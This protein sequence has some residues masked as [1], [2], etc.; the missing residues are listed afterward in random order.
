MSHVPCTL[1]L[2][3]CILIY[4]T[5]HIIVLSTKPNVDNHA[6][7]IW[8]R[9]MGVATIANKNTPFMTFVR[10]CHSFLSILKPFFRWIR[11][12]L[13]L[14]QV[15]RLPDLASFVS[16]MTT[17]TMMTKLITLLLA[18]VHGVIIFIALGCEWL[19]CYSLQDGAVIRKWVWPPYKLN[20]S[21][22]ISIH[23]CRLCT[24]YYS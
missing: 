3:D 2:Q 12:R 21:Q 20:L 18:Y 1:H 23:V 8:A 7:A 15:P 22:S 14:F 10:Q 4:A 19:S 16:T 13:H 5:V 24:I 11:Q 6:Y 17:M 9:S